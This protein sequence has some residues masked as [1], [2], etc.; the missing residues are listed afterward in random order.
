MVGNGSNGIF[1][2]ARIPPRRSSF[3]R[4]RFRKEYMYGKQGAGGSSAMELLPEISD[5]ARRRR[6]LG[7]K[8]RELAA[9][10]GVSQSFVAKVEAGKINPS[11]AMMKKLLAALEA[12]ELGKQ[13][14]V[15]QAMH[16][17][18][19]S[20]SPRERVAAAIQ[21]M[22]HANVSQLPV[23]DR[24]ACV[25]CISERALVRKLEQGETAATLS[26][27]PVS[28]VMEDALP[29]VGEETPL[30]SIAALLLHNPAVLVAK[31]GR[32][33]GIV[34]KSDLLKG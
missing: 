21:R 32:I 18:V 5:F 13:P 25:G 8:Q 4:S 15:K 31:N 1:P 33:I 3:P 28:T 27:L 10:A 6:Q 7:L 11:Y 9:A 26:A 14:R 29:Q 17:G 22:R 30:R 12:R 19:I 34:A 24:G 16:R 23:L 2:A 20:V